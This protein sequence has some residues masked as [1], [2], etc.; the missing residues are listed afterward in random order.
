[1]GSSYLGT[2]LGMYVRMNVLGGCGVFFLSRWIVYVYVPCMHVEDCNCNWP[3]VLFFNF[4]FYEQIP[5]AIGSLLIMIATFEV[6]S[7][8][9]LLLLF[10][11]RTQVRYLPRYD[12][13]HEFLYQFESTW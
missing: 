7:Y 4:L 2:Y 13:I 10:V 5:I 8:L 12:Y 11:R 1:M 9:V 6:T 3:W